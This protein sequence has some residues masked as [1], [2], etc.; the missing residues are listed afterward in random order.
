MNREH[1]STKNDSRSSK[2]ARHDE[3]QP[4]LHSQIRRDS[5][6]TV[7]S[8]ELKRSSG[9]SA[10]K[11]EWRCR[12]QE[13]EPRVDREVVR[14]SREA[15]RGN[16]QRSSAGTTAIRIRVHFDHRCERFRLWWRIRARYRRRNANNS[17]LLEKLY[18][19][20][21]KLRNFRKGAASNR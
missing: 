18:I 2:T 14:L 11:V 10:K 15:Q 8:H 1:A 5:T 9:V 17:L 3:L 16:V 4:N 13:S 6:T 7:R 21:A 20:A 19:S 12:W